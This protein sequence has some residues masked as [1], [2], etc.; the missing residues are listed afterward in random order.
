MDQTGQSVDGPRYFS[1]DHLA[2][3]LIIRAHQEE[4]SR[5]DT[6]G[7][8]LA[9]GGPR[10]RITDRIVLP[11]PSTI[12]YP[13]HCAVSSSSTN[14]RVP[15]RQLA[16]GRSV[17]AESDRCSWLLLGGIRE[18]HF[19]WSFAYVVSHFS[20]ICDKSIALVVKRFSCSSL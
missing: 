4:T 12:R 15:R 17:N 10:D 9:S 20:I 2:R 18:S 7:L 6:C 14:T 13:V 1:H 11:K 3:V 16:G 5:R 19:R 8:D